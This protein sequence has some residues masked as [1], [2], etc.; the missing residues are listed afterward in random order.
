MRSSRTA[1]L[2]SAFARA[3]SGLVL[4][5]LV[6]LAPIG[7]G[8]DGHESGEDETLSVTAGRGL[9]LRH[10]SS[11]HGEDGTG[12]GPVAASLREPPADLTSIRAR[13]GEF[14]A[15]E[16]ARI[17]DGRSLVA[18]HGRREMPVWGR[19][20]SDEMP[21]PETGDQWARGSI[22]VLVDYLRTLQRD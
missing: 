10:C 7:A 16:L 1:N 21:D 15:A 4:G 20:F 5:S 14:P 17:I 2:S 19:R 3:F 18:A 6:A 13:R 9:Y 22:S 11:C 12:N 8:A